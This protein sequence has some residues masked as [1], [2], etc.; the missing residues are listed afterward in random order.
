MTEASGRDRHVAVVEGQL[1]VGAG[2]YRD[3]R[4]THEGR[5]SGRSLRGTWRLVTDLPSDDAGTFTAR[6]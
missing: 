6:R 4:L 5:R 1:E 3:F 2:Q